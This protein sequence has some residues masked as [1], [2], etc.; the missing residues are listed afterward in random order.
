MTRVVLSGGVFQN[1]LL[2]EK[3][4]DL[5]TSGGFQVFTHRLAPPNDGGIALGQAAIAGRAAL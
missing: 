4:Y 1:K 5:L 2:T 3:V